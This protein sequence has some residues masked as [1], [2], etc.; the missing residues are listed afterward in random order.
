[1]VSWMWYSCP[2]SGDAWSGVG[3]KGVVGD[4]IVVEVGGVAY[5]VLVSSPTA[6]SSLFRCVKWTGFGGKGRAS[7]SPLLG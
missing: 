1:M 2:A 3:W 7:S 6:L 4:I 5:A